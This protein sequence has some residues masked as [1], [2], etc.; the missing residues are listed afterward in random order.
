MTDFQALAN[1]AKV[2]ILAIN[3]RSVDTNNL[4]NQHKY[5][6]NIKAWENI[7]YLDI[8]SLLNHGNTTCTNLVYTTTSIENTI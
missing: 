3:Y 8:D 7:T 4:D 5:N 6:Q 2:Y 1:E